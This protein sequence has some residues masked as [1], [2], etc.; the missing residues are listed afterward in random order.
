MNKKIKL[1]A[2]RIKEKAVRAYSSNKESIKKYKPYFNFVKDS[3]ED[4]SYLQLEADKW[5]LFSTVRLAHGV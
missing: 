5:D 2:A 4:L 1:N 3:L